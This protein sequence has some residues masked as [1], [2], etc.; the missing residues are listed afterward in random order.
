VIVHC[1]ACRELVEVNELVASDK[2]G[3][4][5]VACAQ[6]G[7]TTW[8][9]LIDGA[10]SP[11][12][13]PL[14]AKLETTPSAS[15]TEVEAKPKPEAEPEPASAGLDPE[16]R[17]EVRAR[18]DKLDTNEAHAALAGEFAALLDA[19]WD[20]SKAHKRLIQL[21]SAAGALAVLGVRY[22]TILDVLPDDERARS[23]Q[24]E[25]L[26]LATA[27][28]HI[29]GGDIAERPNR[30]KLIALGLAAVIVIATMAGVAYMLRMVERL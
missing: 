23:A 26:G 1:P 16:A 6:C 3:R 27:Q 5:G 4:A 14:S 18:L 9:P 29:A 8:L 10:V 19:G 11:S 30:T 7:V 21:A 15:E 2:E 12:T 17:D 25:I 24:Q 22:R 20:D 28:M 13:A